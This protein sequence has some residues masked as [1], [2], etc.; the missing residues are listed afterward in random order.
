[1]AMAF[2]SA[3]SVSVAF[4]LLLEKSSHASPST[5]VQSPPLQV[6]GKEYMR[7]SAMP[8][9]LPVLSTAIETKV[10]S[11]VPRNQLFMWSEM[12][13]A[14]ERALESLR[15]AMMAAPRFCTQGIMTSVTQASSLI[16]S[17]AALPL[18]LQWL[19]SGYWVDEWFPQMIEPL[20]CSMGTAHLMATW[21]MQR[22]WS[23]RVRA[24]KFFLGMLGATSEAMRQLVLAGLPTTSTL[25]LG[26]ATVFSRSPWTLKMLQFFSRRSLRS[27]PSLRGKAPSM[28]TAS[29][30][31]K[32]TFSSPVQTTPLRRG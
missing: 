23:R 26:E 21:A 11:G 5:M 31:A 6:T 1:M 29:A 7:P 25:T 3:S 17:L 32:A 4:I 19:M 30:P 2:S 12:A 16:R 18:T 15:A 28:M 8:Y 27:M 14:A 10:P 13:W 9:L 20:T 24:E 22:L